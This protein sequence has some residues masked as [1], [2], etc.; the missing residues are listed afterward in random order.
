[1]LCFSLTGKVDTNVVQ[2]DSPVEKKTA[3]AIKRKVKDDHLHFSHYLDALHSFQAFVCRPYLV[4][5]TAHNVR[6]VNQRKIGL[7]AFD[8]KRWWREDTIHTHSHGHKYTVEDQ[9]AL[10]KA[11][12]TVPRRT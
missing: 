9:M 12:L 3:K 4:S 1:M 11:D 5:S 6:T 7:T 10:V 2:R 8:T